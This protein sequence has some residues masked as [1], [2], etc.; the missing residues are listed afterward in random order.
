MRDRGIILRAAAGRVLF[1]TSGRGQRRAAGVRTPKRGPLGRRAQA[2]ATESVTIEF[3][4]FVQFAAVT[5]AA[6]VFLVNRE[7][8]P[9]AAQETNDRLCA[10]EHRAM[11]GISAER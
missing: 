9:R 1:V 2:E 8:Q 6:A 5:V 3:A 4:L 10:L 7:L 11:F